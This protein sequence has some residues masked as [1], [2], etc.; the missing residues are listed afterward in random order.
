MEIGDHFLLYLQFTKIANHRFYAQIEDGAVS[1]WKTC[2]T[3]QR[4]S[5]SAWA[6][7]HRGRKIEKWF[8]D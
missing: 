1:V 4:E 3:M 8:D 5:E 6:G 2:F 7:E